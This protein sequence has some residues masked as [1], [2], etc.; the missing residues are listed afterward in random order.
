M[1][2][3]L[4]LTGYRGCGK[5]TVGRLVAHK[6]AMDFIDSDCAIEAQ[7]G[8]SIAA[9]FERFGEN[10]FRDLESEQ[11]ER[12]KWLSRP[13]VV[14]LGGGAIIR[15]ANRKNIRS[16]GWTVWLQASAD[17]LCDRIS[18]DIQTA[19]RRP[20]L[21]RLGD[22]EEIQSILDLRTKWYDEV[23]DLA[24]ST[25]NQALELVVETVERWFRAKLQMIEIE[26]GPH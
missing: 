10:H 20:K 4:F 23:A 12:L 22:L 8:L 26:N 13:V 14:S 15:E 7:S 24:L 11:I 25:D 9:I 2:Q 3:H 5:S 1:L 16:M 6:L 17:V 21:S 19:S 18:R